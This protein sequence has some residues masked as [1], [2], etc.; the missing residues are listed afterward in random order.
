MTGI[1]R[2]SQPF[3]RYDPYTLVAPIV[4]VMTIW[5]SARRSGLACSV[6]SMCLLPNRVTPEQ[7][8]QPAMN[9]TICII[10]LLLS[11]VVVDAEDDDDDATTDDDDD[12]DVRGWW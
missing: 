7:M 1:L 9:R 4:A 10:R 6:D 12:N 11:V 8:Y 3:T 2:S 5:E